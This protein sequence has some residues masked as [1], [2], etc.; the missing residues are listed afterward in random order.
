MSMARKRQ[1]TDGAAEREAQLR[2]QDSDP[3]YWRQR[4]ENSA[5]LEKAI[6]E[7]GKTPESRLR[8]MLAT[9]DRSLRGLSDQDW[10]VLYNQLR[11]LAPEQELALILPT[12]LHVLP[13]PSPR[14]RRLITRALKELREYLA[15]VAEGK[16][17][18]CRVPA[19]RRRFFPPQRHG[20]GRSRRV[21]MS[22]LF[23]ARGA[24]PASLIHTAA[25]MLIAIGGDRLKRCP[26][27]GS[28]NESPCRKLFLAAHGNR[29]F[30]SDRH[31]AR[32]AYLKWWRTTKGGT[33]AQYRR[34]APS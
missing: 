23:F 12:L 6:R 34:P 14:L 19:G 9:I 32:A 1:A 16:E 8:W 5:R 18:E 28:T 21:T 31:A 13:S 11:Y 4:S 17:Y 30:C 27:E 3:E 2:A 33:R 29:E 26:F 15:A 7:I 20:K 22:T 24:L 10:G 25:D